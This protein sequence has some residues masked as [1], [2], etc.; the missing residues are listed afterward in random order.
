MS[1]FG[2]ANQVQR[3]LWFEWGHLVLSSF[4]LESRHGVF[5]TFT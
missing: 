2:T 1:T 5:H 3:A 4:L